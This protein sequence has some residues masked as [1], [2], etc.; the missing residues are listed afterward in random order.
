MSEDLARLQRALGYHFQDEPALLRALTHRSASHENNERLEFLGDA[1]LNFAV[2]EAMFLTQPKAAE[3][4]LS[5]LRA[6]LV[7][8]ET[9]AS[10]ARRIQLGEV[11]RLGS[12]ELKSG[13]FRR[14]SILAD[15]LEA[16]IGAVYL[17]GGFEAARAL[18]LRLLEPELE[19][20]PDPL[21]LKDAKTR[22]QERLQAAGRPLPEYTVLS[23]EGPPHRRSFKVRC[24][25]LDDQA[26][27]AGEGASRKFA[28]QQ[29]AERMLD[30][31]A[32]TG[33]RHA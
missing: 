23:E 29:S 1:L 28:E 12:G 18:C 33:A 32:A 16:I 26:E 10:V 9:L 3:G 30:V 24:R 5:R 6:T 20:L 11:I 4:D 2:G 17:D 19:H 21:N 13:G 7:R 14:D 25:L 15:G 27:T 31:L 22:L 8:E